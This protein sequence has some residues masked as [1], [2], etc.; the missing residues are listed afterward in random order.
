M[1]TKGYETDICSYIL[2]WKPY[3]QNCHFMNCHTH[4]EYIHPIHAWAKRST[5]NIRHSCKL[6]YISCHIFILILLML[7]N[8][9]VCI[10]LTL[11]WSKR[12]RTGKIRK[13]FWCSKN[14]PEKMLYLS[15]V[16]EYIISQRV[17]ISHHTSRMGKILGKQ[18]IYNAYIMFSKCIY[19]YPNVRSFYVI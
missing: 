14:L 12:N 17:F 10:N 3:S 11:I 15:S 8:C 13:F 9:L 5:L 6:I 16:L 18:W 4:A 1:L 7:Y 19:M 2:I